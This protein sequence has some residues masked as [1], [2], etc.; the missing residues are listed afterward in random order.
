MCLFKTH[1][2]TEKE[3]YQLLIHSS[4]VMNSQSWA[5]GQPGV[6]VPIESSDKLQCHI[7][8]ALL[9]FFVFYKSGSLRYSLI[10]LFGFASFRYRF[11]FFKFLINLCSY[12]V[13][14]LRCFSSVSCV[15]HFPLSSV[16]CS[17]LPIF[18]FL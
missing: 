12:M 3:I 6:W 11:F 2:D 9:P 16:S 10:Y 14:L 1:R 4:D 13:S 17:S 5:A 18:F 7:S 8:Y 15:Y